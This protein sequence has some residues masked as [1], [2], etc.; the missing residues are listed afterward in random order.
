MD[1]QVSRGVALYHF[2][3]YVTDVVKFVYVDQMCLLDT[4]L[5]RILKKRM[6]R[7]IKEGWLHSGDIG[8]WR[9]DGTLQIIDRK[10]NIFKLSQGEY[11]A[12]EK[13]EKYYYD[14]S[15]SLKYLFM[16]IPIKIE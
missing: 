8:L 15:I 3:K 7:L 12:P 13:I 6:K 10:K 9:P 16:V 11:D 4:T 2:G 1:R 14:P 5:T